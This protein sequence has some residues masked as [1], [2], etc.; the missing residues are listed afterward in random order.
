MAEVGV[1]KTDH[2]LAHVVTPHDD[3]LGPME[4][5]SEGLPPSHLFPAQIDP[6][7]DDCALYAQALKTAGVA[8]KNHT[9]VGDGLVHGYLRAR[10]MSDK[11]G[12]NFQHICATVSALGRGLS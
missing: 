7:F 9:Q 8:V 5:P 6:L 10:H 3:F 4:C 2:Q 12:A 11:A 1:N